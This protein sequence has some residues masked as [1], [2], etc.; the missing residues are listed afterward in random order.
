MAWS[1]GYVFAQPFDKV[2]LFTVMSIRHKDMYLSRARNLLRRKQ[3]KTWVIRRKGAGE[4]AHWAECLVLEKGDLS[5]DPQGLL[6]ES[7]C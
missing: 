3:K 6:K 7:A 2:W 5:L 1:D 4:V